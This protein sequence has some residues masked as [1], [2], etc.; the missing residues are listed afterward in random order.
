MIPLSRNTLARLSSRLRECV[1]AGQVARRIAAPQ[2]GAR[3]RETGL[4]ASLQKK[5]KAA[6]GFN[7]YC[8]NFRTRINSFRI[9]SHRTRGEFTKREYLSA[10][11]LFCAGPP[12]NSGLGKI[13]P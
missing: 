7:Q 10:V 13:Y 4:R 9:I 12:A 11:S 2:R 6:C 3:R 8:L 5:E 1:P